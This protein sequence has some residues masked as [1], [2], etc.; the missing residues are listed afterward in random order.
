MKKLQFD[1]Y[2]FGD[3]LLEGL[4][5]IAYHEGI[6]VEKVKIHPKDNCPYWKEL[7]CKLWLKRAKDHA[8]SLLERTDDVSSVIKLELT[9]PKDLLKTIIGG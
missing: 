5:F 7:N 9:D 3:K 6:K 8:E 4:R 1:G 2:D